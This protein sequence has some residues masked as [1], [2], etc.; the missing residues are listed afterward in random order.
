MCAAAQIFTILVG[1]MNRFQ[2]H[3]VCGHFPDSFCQFQGHR[4][5]GI[6]Y[7]QP[8]CSSF[9]LADTMLKLVFLFHREDL[10]KCYIIA[11]R[12]TFSKDVC[13]GC[14]AWHYWADKK[15]LNLV[16]Q[17]INSVEQHFGGVTKC[18]LWVTMALRPTNQSMKQSSIQP[19]NELVLLNNISLK[20]YAL[21][22]LM[23]IKHC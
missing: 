10:V 14:C 2:Y 9:F 22:D 12:V 6:C 23:L 18:Y 1:R 5:F 16:I 11:F 19:T 17:P 3:L 7:L 13:W 21:C 20:R 8:S 15:T 4:K